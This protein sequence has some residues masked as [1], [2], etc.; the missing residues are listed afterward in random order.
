MQRYGFVQDHK[1]IKITLNTLINLISNNLNYINDVQQKKIE[2]KKGGK[3]CHILSPLLL[4]I[5]LNYIL[6]K[7]MERQ[8]SKE[9]ISTLE[10]QSAEVG[11]KINANKNMAMRTGIGKHFQPKRNKKS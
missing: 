2:V 3:Q 10:I 1:I 4:K 9:M 6:D 8:N 11:L 7:T 5:C